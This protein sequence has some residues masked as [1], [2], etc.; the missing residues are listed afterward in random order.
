MPKFGE[1]LSKIS[2]RELL[3][4]QELED[5]KKY[6]Q[7]KL[8]LEKG[9]NYEKDELI[10]KLISLV[11][12][13]FTSMKENTL[14]KCLKWVKK[15]LEENLEIKVD[16][17]IF[18]NLEKMKEDKPNLKIKLGWM[19]EYSLLNKEE[20]IYKLTRKTLEKYN[21]MTFKSKDSNKINPSNRRNTL[22]PELLKSGIMNRINEDLL[23][24]ESHKF[25]IFKLEQKV[26]RENILPVTSTYI[27]STLGLFSII[28]YTKFEPFI[29]RVASGYHRENPYHTDLHAA[30]ICQSLLV[31]YIFGNLQKLLDFNDLDL[32]SLFISAAIH[33][34]GHPGF[35]NNFLINS[36]DD[37]AIRYNDQS[38]LENFHVSEGF[39]IILKK[40]G[41][42]IFESMSND[43]YKFCRKRIIQCV[44]ATD[45]TLHNKEFQF[46]KT[47]I[48]NFQIKNGQNVEKILEVQDPIAIFNTKQDF[49][50]ILI[51]SADISNPTKPLDIYKQWA[52][53]CVDEF[54]RQ[55]DR[56]KRLGLPVSFGCDRT[57]VTLPQSQLGF[58]DAIVFP[59]F[60]VVNE[61]FPGMNFTLQNLKINKEYYKGQK[62]MDEKKKINNEIK[63]EEEDKNEN[64]DD[65]SKQNS[66]PMSKQSKSSD[67]E[68]EK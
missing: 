35:T 29:F 6:S 42:N 28:D 68:S 16:S 24:F 2:L 17:S 61:F 55:G 51:H 27:F 13:K 9:Y 43:D 38:V 22:N 56:E 49:L 64:S 54:F 52:Q 21:Q 25:N 60:S 3:N 15:I 20:E 63:E 14:V 12:D 44:L 59:L 18:K 11:I 50:N 33:D 65:D 46:L 8:G 31:Y 37:K 36:K 10:L 66:G 5:I 39:N 26:G 67:T 41:C 58:I 47:K 45:M 7:F 30:D 34:L 4:E 32:I 19:E 40:N 57:I 23:D 48:Q 1:S 62:D 53:R